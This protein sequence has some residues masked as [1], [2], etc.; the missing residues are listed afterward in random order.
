MPQAETTDVWYAGKTHD[1]GGNI[2]ALFYPSGIAVGLR[3]PAGRPDRLRRPDRRH[4]P[5][6]LKLLLSLAF[7]A[8]HCVRTGSLRTLAHTPS[9]AS[10][11]RCR[12]GGTSP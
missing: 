10:A 8:F 1:F 7:M 12:S 5:V 9:L 3:C 2:Q 11:T 6:G 4:Q